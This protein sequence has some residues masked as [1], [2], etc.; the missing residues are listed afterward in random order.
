M[1]VATILHIVSNSVV[2]QFICRFSHSHPIYRVNHLLFIYLL[3]TSFQSVAKQSFLK[4]FEP[5]LPTRFILHPLPVNIC[6]CS[7][8]GKFK[9]KL[10]F[11]PPLDNHNL[12]VNEQ[13]GTPFWTPTR[14]LVKGLYVTGNRFFKL[15]LLTNMV[16]LTLKKISKLSLSGKFLWISEIKKFDYLCCYLI[17]CLVYYIVW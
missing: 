6:Y 4:W 3:V 9:G 5:V 11:Q 15:L 1:V 12:G 10:D 17:P 8:L 2:T 7:L 16:K 14:F 13:C